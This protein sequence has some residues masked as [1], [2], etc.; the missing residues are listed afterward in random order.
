M[1]SLS[2]RPPTSTTGCTALLV[3]L[4]LLGAGCTTTTV[5]Q[6]PRE[7]PAPSA[8]PDAQGDP[9]RRA[10]ARY[11]L[12]AAYLGRGQTE[13]ALEEIRAALAAKPD[14]WEAWNLRA[15]AM[16][17]LGQVPEAEASFRRAL[18]LKPNDPD[19][20]HNH[21]WFLC[22]SQRYAEAEQQFAQALAQPQYRQ[23]SRTLL[24]QGVCQ[25]RNGR[26]DDAERSLYR[27][28]ELD[29]SNPATAVNLSEVLLRRNELERARF[30]IGR[31]NAQAEQSNAQTLWLAARIERRAGN[32]PAVQDFGR[33]LLDRY[34][35]SREALAYQQGRFDE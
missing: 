4:L 22:Q 17:S 34:P 33:R 15:L 5:Q 35:Q 26:W 19:V 25:A 16:A 8:T 11:E 10:R 13:T 29:P 24:A 7:E 3:A 30:Y 12:A 1:P 32:G 9:D 31:V 20:L 21:G 14:L 6:T 18:Q 23:P 28:Y 27:S 2:S